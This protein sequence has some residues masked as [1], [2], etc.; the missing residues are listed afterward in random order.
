MCPYYNSKQHKLGNCKQFI[1]LDL[2]TRHIF[3]QSNNLCFNC[4]GKNHS[5]NACRITT[6]CSICRKKH[7]SLFHSRQYSDQSGLADPEVSVGVNATVSNTGTLNEDPSTSNNVTAHLMSHAQPCQ[8]LLA[9]CKSAS[10]RWRCTNI[11]S[12]VRSRFSSIACYRV[13]SAVAWA[14]KGK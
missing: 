8:I 14:E 1:Y 7:H 2:N 6:K 5:A 9:T 4:V 11:T 3:V 13:C 10:Q 12:F